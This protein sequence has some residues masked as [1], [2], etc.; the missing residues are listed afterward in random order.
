MGELSVL[1]TM[2]FGKYRGELIGTVIENDADYI[3][4]AINNT[5]LRLNEDATRYLM[6]NM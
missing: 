1:D 6:E 3:Y 4:W 2:P 5:E